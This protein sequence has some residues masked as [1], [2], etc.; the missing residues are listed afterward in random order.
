MESDFTGELVPQ[1]DEGIEKA[2]WVAIEEVPNKLRNSY[3]T[4]QEVTNTAIEYY[5]RII[6]KKQVL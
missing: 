1:L 6:G 4:I 5:H 2:E 3:R